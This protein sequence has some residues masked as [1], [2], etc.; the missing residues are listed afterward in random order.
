MVPLIT[1]LSDGLVDPAHHMPSYLRS[2]RALHLRNNI[3]RDIQDVKGL[4][5]SHTLIDLSKNKFLDRSPVEHK[6]LK[7]TLLLCKNA[8]NKSLLFL[9]DIWDVLEER[10]IS[11]VERGPIKG[12]D[13]LV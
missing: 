5:L 3:I 6:S 1:N 13:L 12:R 2:N 9:R 11:T 4:K 7:D 10:V 8:I